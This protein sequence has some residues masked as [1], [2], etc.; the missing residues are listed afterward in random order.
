VPGFIYINIIA[1]APPDTSSHN[2]YRILISEAELLLTYLKYLYE[3]NRHYP[4]FGG[5]F[6]AGF[7]LSQKGE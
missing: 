2:I 6:R 7:G 3:K 5:Y 1:E 4:A